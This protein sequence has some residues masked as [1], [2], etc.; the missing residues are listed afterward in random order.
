MEEYI[1]SETSLTIKTAT[2]GASE[3]ALLKYCQNDKSR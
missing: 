2:Y 3:F 1:A